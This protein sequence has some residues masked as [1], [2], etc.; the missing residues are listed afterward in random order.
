MRLAA[1]I[2]TKMDKALAAMTVEVV[3]TDDLAVLQV[4]HA[5]LIQKAEDLQTK[6]DRLRAD[7][8]DQAYRY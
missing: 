7:E 8:Y 3:N 2:L 5:S 4:R 6:I 1:L